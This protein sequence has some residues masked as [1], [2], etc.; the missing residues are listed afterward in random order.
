[1]DFIM[2]NWTMIIS[3][4][5]SIVGGFSIIA[6]MTPNKADNMIVEKMVKFVNFMGA[7][8]GKAKNA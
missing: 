3:A 7:N 1:M 6:T 2:E 4:M 8:F 5:T